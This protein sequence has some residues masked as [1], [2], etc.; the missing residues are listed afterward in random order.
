MPK[1]VQI[2]TDV[3]YPQTVGTDDQGPWGASDEGRAEL[4]KWLERDY[5]IVSTTVT[6]LHTP[7]VRNLETVTDTRLV[8]VTT[9]V[10]K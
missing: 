2:L 4:E 3:L 10:E 6:T 1:S 5:E 9:L 7:W 8:L